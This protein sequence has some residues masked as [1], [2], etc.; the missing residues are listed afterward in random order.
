M[1][2][3]AEVQAWASEPKAVWGGG[4]CPDVEVDS[5]CSPIGVSVC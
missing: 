5:D 4:D 2:L 3:V 1:C